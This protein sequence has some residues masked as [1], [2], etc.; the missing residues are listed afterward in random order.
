MKIGQS[1]QDIQIGDEARQSKTITQ[2]DVE[3]FGDI[4]QDHNPAHFDEDYAK[5]TMF[6]TRISHG[7]LVGS[8]F[9][10][11]IGT[12]LPGN[13]TIYTKQSLKFTNPVYFNDVITATITVT[14]I[15]T[16]KNRVTLDC[17]AVNQDG[18][19]VIVGEAEVMP[20]KKQEHNDE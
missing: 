14:H 15:N 5:Q 2:E 3:Q 8:L 9:S 1:I 7:M 18:E 4:I 10:G 13:G 11:L 19:V 16:D 6:K 12:K 17:K 20:P